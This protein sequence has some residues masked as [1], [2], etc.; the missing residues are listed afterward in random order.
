MYC[1]DSSSYEALEFCE[2]LSE[3]TKSKKI[4]R[5]THEI[6]GY[7]NNGNGPLV[8]EIIFIDNPCCLSHAL[9]DLENSFR[10]IC[11]DEYDTDVEPNDYFIESFDVISNNDQIIEIQL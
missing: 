1:I 6:R 10:E 11:E 4:F 9:Q 2:L 5:V 3:A 8:E 7:L